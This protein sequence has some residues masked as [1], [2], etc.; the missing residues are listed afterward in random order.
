MHPWILNAQSAINARLLVTDCPRSQKQADIW[1][2]GDK[3]GIDFR[4]GT[5]IPLTDQN[6]MTSFKSSGI[7]C[8]SVGNLLLLT[9]GKRVWNKNLAL[10]DHA[11]SLEGDLG[12]TQ[13]CIIV[14][15]PDNP[16][17]YYIFTIDV[18]AFKPDN[19]YTTNGLKYTVIDMTMYNG[20]GDARD[21][22]NMSLLNPVCQKLT[23]VK[24]SNHRDFWVIVHQWNSN[25]FYSYLLTPSGLQSPVIS[26]AGTIMGGGFIDQTNAYGYMKAS[27]DGSKLGLAI[28]GLNKVELFD[29]NNSTGS[30]SNPRS[31]TTTDP[32]IAPYGIEFSPDNKKMYTTLLQIVG[33]GPPTTHSRLYQFDLNAGFTAPVLIDT[34]PG[35]RVGG[36]QLATDGRIYLA[37]TVNIL[38]KRDQN[39]ILTLYATLA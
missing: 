26:N 13:P 23:A 24:H 25:A 9:D 29:F 21:T 30:V 35:E 18:M 16:D 11:N 31:F 1:Y 3:S 4:S 36:M 20:L 33:N 14:P 34:I 6:V 5:A 28:S 22:M 27:P 39:N 8:D 32:G 12:V 19:S 7:I 37:R 2:F 38:T 15:L 17:R 10:M